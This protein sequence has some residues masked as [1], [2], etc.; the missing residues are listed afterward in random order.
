MLVFESYFETAILLPLCL[1]KTFTATLTATNFQLLKTATFE[2]S[3]RTVRKDFA[4]SG[5]CLY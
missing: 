5:Y 2:E 4:A 1:Q 3:G